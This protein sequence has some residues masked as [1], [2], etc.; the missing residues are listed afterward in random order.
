MKT[1]PADEEPEEDMGDSAIR[2]CAQDLISAVQAS[3]VKGVAEAIR[4]MFEIMDSQPHVEG[5]HEPHS[6]DA[7]DED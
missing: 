1:R 3:D 2:A 4:S 7:Q 5:E 6:Y